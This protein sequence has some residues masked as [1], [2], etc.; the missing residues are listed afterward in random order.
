[1][2]FIAFFLTSFNEYRYELKV[3]EGAFDFNEGGRKIRSSD[4]GFATYIRYSFYEW[5]SILLCI[6]LQWKLCNDIDEIW[7]EITWLM[8]VNRFYKRIRNAETAVPY[9]L[10]KP[11]T[12]FIKL[13]E[14]PRWTRCGTG[15]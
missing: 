14:R 1:M 10:G 8:E 11:K 5:V 13:V 7:D 4:M 6:K 9:A 2:G 3:A 15:S 12:D